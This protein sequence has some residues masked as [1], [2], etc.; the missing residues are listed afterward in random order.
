MRA[1]V[2]LHAAAALGGLAAIAWVCH[3]LLPWWLLGVPVLAGGVVIGVLGMLALQA[4]RPRR[5][6]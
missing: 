2:L 4:V 6:G 5:E 1:G 3:L